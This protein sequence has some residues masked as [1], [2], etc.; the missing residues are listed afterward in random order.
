MTL[1]A[2]CR[3]GNS[4][5]HANR[6][7]VKFGRTFT[8]RSQRLTHFRLVAGN[9]I[10]QTHA[11]IPAKPMRVY[12]V[13]PRKDHRGVAL[14]WSWPWPSFGARPM[15]SRLK[16]YFA[17]AMVAFLAACQTTNQG[18]PRNQSAAVN[19]PSDSPSSRYETEG[20][21][22][23]AEGINWSHGGSFIGP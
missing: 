3:L 12:K 4:S 10:L 7:A 5:G 23:F 9:R 22:P 17:Y 1:I 13:R 15:E 14:R 20:L 2:T 18:S 8:T 21:N 16:S 6:N 19:G 11:P